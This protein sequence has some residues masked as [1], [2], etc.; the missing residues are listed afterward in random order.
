MGHHILK[1][2]KQSTINIS[3]NNKLTS[4]QKLA[5]YKNIAYEIA[6]Q[7]FNISKEHLFSKFKKRDSADIRRIIAK[8]LKTECPNIGN[9]LI[10]KAVGR[11][12]SN[13]VIQLEYHDFLIK[14]NNEYYQKFLDFQIE[15]KNMVLDKSSLSD[16]KVEKERLK[17]RLRRVNK[18][19]NNI[20]SV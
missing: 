18:L 1:K 9:E 12:R 19:I 7:K 13:T 20:E 3:M 16:L 14:N 5:N 4:I 8:L 17:R 2:I 15:F 6:E 10:G 11:K